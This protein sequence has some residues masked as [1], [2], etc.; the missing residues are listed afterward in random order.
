M[1]FESLGVFFYLMFIIHDS[2]VDILVSGA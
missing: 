2:N 1:F